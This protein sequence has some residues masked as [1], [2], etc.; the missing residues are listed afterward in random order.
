VDGDGGESG[1]E[2]AVGKRLPVV[3][4]AAVYR[5]ADSGGGCPHGD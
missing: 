2:F 5:R 3:I 1:D 4:I